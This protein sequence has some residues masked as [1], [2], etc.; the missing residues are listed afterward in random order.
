M[1]RIAIDENRIHMVFEI[2]Q[3]KVRLV[4]FSAAEL[5][6]STLGWRDGKEMYFPA[7]IQVTGRNR[8]SN[9]HG[10]K[11]VE[12]SPGYEMRYA[13]LRDY[14]N[15]TGRKLEWE[16]VHEETGLHMTVHY[17]FF[18]GIPVVRT[19]TEVTNRGREAQ[20]LEAVSTFCLMGLGK[21]GLLRP[22]QKMRLYVPHHSWKRE[23]HW[24]TY[25]FPD[26]GLTCTVD[27]GADEIESTQVFSVSNTGNWSTKEYLPMGY[28][29]DTEAGVSLYWQ[30]EHNGSWHWEISDYEGQYYLELGGPD[31]LHNHWWKNLM[32]G[33]TFTS[34]SFCQGGAWIF[35]IL[36]TQILPLLLPE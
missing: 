20:G 7:E 21:E 2:R 5:D 35:F 1:K 4:H 24:N 16:I 12:T 25:S 26:L 10:A 33:E 32:P 27:P 22:D 30:I 31:E 8:P 34:E 19:W 23:M 17:Q 14:R 6:E 29:E 28:L 15:D 36:L 11:I 13:A 9:W 18:D 3:D